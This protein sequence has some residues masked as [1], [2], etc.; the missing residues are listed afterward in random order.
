MGK[1]S[2]KILYIGGLFRGSTGLERKKVLEKLGHS[3]IPFDTDPYVRNRNRIELSFTHRL[4]WGPAIWSLNRD[5]VKFAQKAEYDLVWVSKGTWIF[6]STVESFKKSG[7]ATIVHFTP[8]SQLFLNRTRYFIQS[9]PVYDVLITS[10]PWELDNYR[11][12]GARRVV[13][14][15]QGVNLELFKPY[16]ISEQKYDRLRSDVCFIGRC[17]SH[18]RHCIKVIYN[19]GVKLAVWGPWQRYFW[20]CPSLKKVVRG[21]G[22][23][24]EDYAKAI[25][26]A[27]IGLGLLSK[28]FPETATT[29]TF[30]IPACGT[31]LLAERTDEHLGYFEEGK[32]AEFFASDEEMQ[33]K[34]KYYLAHDEEREK[35]ARAGLARC[36]K[37]GYSIESRIQQCLDA[38][39]ES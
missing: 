23:W 26:C 8:D 6:P 28:L 39:F 18:Y 14:I 33:D 4:A 36:F 16:N 24:H 15:P 20:V 12:C 30:E 34:I 11:N 2:M 7:K 31:F 3:I 13:N 21:R 32:E 22:I 17:E 10:K 37:S 35:I 29:R 27:K 25:C 9:I 19:T 1:R 5:A 38:I